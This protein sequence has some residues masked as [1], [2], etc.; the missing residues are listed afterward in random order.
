[1]R[2]VTAPRARRGFTLIELAV[3]CAI[4]GYL[5]YAVY[6]VFN[7]MQRYLAQADASVMVQQSA[8]ATM[9]KLVLEMSET[10]QSLVVT[11]TSGIVG[12]IFPS[13]RLEGGSA[14][15]FDASGRANFQQWVCYYLD[16]T[17][18]TFRRKTISIA[19]PTA[20]PALG[21]GFSTPSL[22]VAYSGSG[23]A[24]SRRIGGDAQTFSVV[25]STMLRGFTITVAC[26]RVTYG[27]QYGYSIQNFVAPRNH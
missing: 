15:T 8:Y 18:S 9:K 19:T 25:A 21:A 26:Q 11:S 14:C 20:N 7:G 22:F 5:T 27:K 12:V 3:Y 16:A 1:M 23:A 24:P 13:P 4:L 17:T 2:A 6:Q 10:R